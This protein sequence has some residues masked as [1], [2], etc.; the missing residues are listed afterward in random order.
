MVNMLVP[1]G[2]T[3]QDYASNTVVPYIANISKNVCRIDLVW[4]RY[5]EDSFKGGTRE[6]RGLGVRRKV[7]SSN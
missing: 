3:F 7:T 5:F 1:A 4:D 2:K 6:K